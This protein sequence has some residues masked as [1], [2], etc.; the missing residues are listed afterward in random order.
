MSM[1]FLPMQICNHYLLIFFS[2]CASCWEYEPSLESIH[3]YAPL[4]VMVIAIV[5]ANRPYGG[6]P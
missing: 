4:D 1:H 5:V 6:L 3:E 2:L